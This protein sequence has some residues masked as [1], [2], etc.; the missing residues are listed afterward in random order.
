MNDFTHNKLSLTND[1]ALS[2]Q[3]SANTIQTKRGL[4]FLTQH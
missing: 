3:R 1:F 4:L 2:M